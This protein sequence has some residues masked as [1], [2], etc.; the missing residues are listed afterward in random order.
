M[1]GGPSAVDKARLKNYQR[2]HR[3][4]WLAAALLMSK[5]YRILARRLKTPVGE[6][7]LIAVRGRRLAFVE[8]KQRRTVLDC[9]ASITVRTSQRVHRAASLWVARKPRFH[10][11]DQGFDLVFIT[12]WAWPVY[13]PDAL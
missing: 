12:P 5:G 4:E 9:E 2:G 10:E 7:D 13:R 6:I 3:A 11:H 1:S 8:V